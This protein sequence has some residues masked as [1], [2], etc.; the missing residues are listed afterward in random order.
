MNCD[1]LF[2]LRVESCWLICS[3]ILACSQVS[4]SG[5]SNMGVGT[6]NNGYSFTALKD[7]RISFEPGLET[8]SSNL[9]ATE[10]GLGR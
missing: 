7:S 9:D 6:S 1:D 5:T 3:A 8:A 10:Y 2:G 4:A